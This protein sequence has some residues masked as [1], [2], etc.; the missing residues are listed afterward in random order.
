VTRPLKRYT[1]KRDFSATPEPRGTV[2]ASAGPLA[3]VVQKHWA[4]RLHYDFRLELDGVLVSWA[5]P[6]G[7][8]FDPADQRLAVHVEDHPLAYAGFEG[9]IPK[10]QYGAGRVIVWDR[11]TW[12]PVG[13]AHAAL[14][15]GKLVF[16]LHGEKLAG[17]W[18]LMRIAKPGDRSEAWLL[19]KKRDA[20]SRPLAEYD[21]ISALPDSVVAHP[22]GLLEQR[23]PRVA[24]AAAPAATTATS[25]TGPTSA[26]AL[27]GATP[28]PLPSALAPQL[29]QAADAAPTRGEWI[30]ELK[31]DGYRLLARIDE[32]GAVRLFTRQGHDWTA[33]LAPL[34]AAIG[35]RR[36]P[37]SWLDGEIVVPGPSGVPDFN[38]LQNAIDGRRGAAAIR[39]FLFDLPFHDGHDLRASPLAARR[40]LLERLLGQGAPEAAAADPVLRFSAAF[41]ADPASLLES[42]RALGLEGL[43][44]KRADARYVSGRDALWL[45]VKLA[46]RQEFV[47][48]GWVPRE[49][50][51]REVGA[52][53]L[54]LHE[55]DGRLVH[56]GSVGTGWSAATAAALAA[57]LA[58]LEQAAPPFDAGSPDPGRWGRRGAGAERWL[59]PELVAEV[60]FAGFT[61]AG[62]VRHAVF[63]ALRSDKPAR[64]VRREPV[65]RPAW[66]V[67][68][69]RLKVTHPERVIDPSTGLTKLDLVRYYDSVAERMLPHLAGRPLALVRGPEG[70]AGAL[71]FQKHDEGGGLA[72]V[73]ALDP[74]LAPGHPPLVEVAGAEGLVAAAQ[75]NVI[76]FHTWNATARRIDHPDRI[77]FDL[78]PGAGLPWERVQEAALLVRTLLDELGLACWLKTSGGKGLHVVVPVAPRRPWDEV[79]G[80]AQAAVQHLVRTIPSRFV[81]KAGAPNRIGKLFV[82]VLRNTRGA[83]SAAAFSARARPG[84]GVSMPVAWEQLDTLTGG[85][86]WNIASAREHLSFETADPWAGFFGT[87]QTLG[88]A[89]RTLA[90]A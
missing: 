1:E 16:D 65:A 76:E 42:A 90:R 34:A 24:A 86:M 89:L 75:M 37:A 71:F 70:V 77:V 7:L 72:G 44:A 74:A 15:A 67:A 78:D 29:A 80:F 57:Q 36:W 63:V 79:Y 19:F 50:R 47:L 13:G 3:F 25:A 39:Y 58:P 2:A 84:L 60:R 66:P 32:A 73:H 14:A 64:D 31:F 33:R 6:K 8:S 87:R 30:Y 55:A 27:P 54:G 61:P 21:V 11:G 35:Q 83:T 85:A 20:W 41:V 23:Q 40:A 49:G 46:T 9:T 12:A 38:A 88:A 45:K 17:R 81:A 4:S 68:P 69:T 18:E 62:H 22:L 48:G 59:R 82:D 26:A 52:L 10:G 5:L 43:I 53:I 56:A 28:A 51:A